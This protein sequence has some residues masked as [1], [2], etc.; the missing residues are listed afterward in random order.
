MLRDVPRRFL[1]RLG[2][3]T[4]VAVV[5]QTFYVIL[6]HGHRVF[7][8]VEYR[9]GDAAFFQVQA[10]LLAGGRFF[11]QPFPGS[12]GGLHSP[13]ADHPPIFTLF[14]TGLD[15]IGLTTYPQH[16]VVC[17]IVGAAIGVFCVGLLGREVGGGRVGY[18]SAVAFAAYVNVWI[19]EGIAVSEALAIPLT[20][21]ALLTVFRFVREPSWPRAAWL[22]LA[23]S[24]CA[25]TRAELV[26]LFPL[27]ALPAALAINKIKIHHQNEH[28]PEVSWKRRFQ[29]LVVVGVVGIVAMGPWVAR[30]LIVFD[31]PTYLSTGLGLTMASG[32]CDDTFSG[33]FLGYWS[34]PCVAF[35]KPP[36]GDASD[37]DAVWRTR[38]I[39]Y[40]KAHESEIPKVLYARLGRVWGF[41]RP[42]Q[43]ATFDE[44]SDGKEPWL[45]VNGLAEYYLFAVFAIGGVV[46]LRRRRHMQFPLIS[47]FGIVTFSIL[48]TFGNTRYRAISEPSLVVLAAVGMDAFF[49]W[50]M[51]RERRLN[52]ETPDPRI[53]PSDEPQDSISP[54][55]SAS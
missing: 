27:A 54:G 31:K 23:C 11:I 43:Q 36:P 14:L 16:Q 6:N 9:G 29:L 15:K 51:V 24:L 21:L 20:A 45:A 35:E 17:A 33:P 44:F 22:G 1:A 10:K 41:Y 4:A 30:N 2:I 25:L 7:N 55:L 26:L 39:N 50:M 48:L 46:V 52:G 53:D 13:S 38:T 8:P 37:V 12:A 40:L 3:I 34:F 19:F 32:T 47:L 5:V 28:R 18:I 49:S 42:D